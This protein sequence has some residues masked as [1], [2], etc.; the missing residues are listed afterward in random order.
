MEPY[1]D[2]YDTIFDSIKNPKP[3]KKKRKKHKKDNKHKGDSDTI[4]D[5]IK[6]SKYLKKGHKKHK[7]DNKHK[8]HFDFF[9]N[10]SFDKNRLKAFFLWSLANN[11]ESGTLQVIEKVKN[12]G[13]EYATKGGVSLGI[14]DLKIPPNKKW[15]LS[16]GEYNQYQA[17]A[18]YQKGGLSKGEQFQQLF[19]TWH[20]TSE[21]LKYSVIDYFR[22]TD[23]LNPVF[24]MAFSGA[25]GNI[26]QVRQ[27][28][29]M[30]GLMSDPQG[31]IIDYPIRSNFREGLTLTEYLVSCYGARKGVVDTALRTANAG[32]LT[33][34][35]VD[36][37][38]HVIIYSDDCKTKDGIFL[39]DLK[40]NQKIIINLKDR[41]IGRVLAG[42]LNII[43][44][45]DQQNT[46]PIYKKNDTISKE[47]ASHIASRSNK[48]F[49]RSPITCKIKG[50]VC[51]SCYGS[52][53]DQNF[54]V[55]FGEAVG[56]LAAQSIG[57][58]GTQLTMRTFHTGGV[59][60]GDLQEAIQAPYKGFIEFSKALQG[61]VF[62]T[63]LGKPAFFT[64]AF[65]KLIIKSLDSEVN[66]T[67]IDIPPKTILFVRQGEIVRENQ[68]ICELF[69]LSTQNDEKIRA[70]HTHY[71]ELEGKVVFNK[72]RLH[73]KNQDKVFASFFKKSTEQVSNFW[74]LS[75][76]VS[77][78][79]TR[80][81]LVSKI[82]DLVDKKTLLNRI[83]FTHYGFALISRS[84][85]IS[86]TYRNLRFSDIKNEKEQIG[87]NYT[88]SL[89]PPVTPTSFK[90]SFITHNALF[91]PIKSADTA[92]VRSP[93]AMSDVVSGVM[94]A[95]SM[96]TKQSG[97]PSL[98]LLL[99]PNKK[100]VS[101][102]RRVTPTDEFEKKDNLLKNGLK[103]KA[104]FDFNYL[105]L[106]IHRFV[107][108]NIQF[109]SIGY[110][111]SFYKTNLPNK[112]RVFDRTIINPLFKNKEFLSPSS[113][114][115]KQ[116]NNLKDFNKRKS[117]TYKINIKE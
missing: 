92:F 11:G 14:D 62:R 113:F 15:L 47:L 35:L 105:N 43:L 3:L 24:M 9:F 38:Q 10:Y 4:F 78:I 87:C 85:S 101:G 55:P 70:R 99:T 54:P 34:R 102:K 64:K 114:L 94:K 48:I 83:T 36:V 61:T 29:G 5:S 50:S 91:T 68:L 96:E 84:T 21:D 7:E 44:F 76:K 79:T 93:L 116:G 20:R 52:N 75:G 57:E 30:R 108:K 98:S 106:P 63:S 110:F 17:E 19:D 69:S 66:K 103:K 2:I 109:S 74:V 59:F 71:S 104:V 73:N 13:F 1:L 51:Q 46:R 33:R 112:S 100:A 77:K 90:S 31:Q 67:E 95:V 25:R 41:L 81:A 32:Y 86:P 23:L 16:R 88:L 72:S 58:P 45:K 49:V 12:I 80:L 65:G 26:S 89:Q 18:M 56:I 82:G 8:G 42:D 115:R 27:L 28:V 37:S 6:N 39:T 117:Y 40:K 22:S 107:F 97:D 60:S 53:L 111:L